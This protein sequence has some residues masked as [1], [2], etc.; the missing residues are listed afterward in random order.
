MLLAASWLMVQLRFAVLN[1]RDFLHHLVTRP[2]VIFVS[3]Q[4]SQHLYNHW[5]YSER[6]LHYVTLEHDEARIYVVSEISEN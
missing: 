6:Q 4:S 2:A 5:V 1:S 3:R